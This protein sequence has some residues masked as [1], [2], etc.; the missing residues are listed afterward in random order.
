M[1]VSAMIAS[2]EIWQTT[3]VLVKRYGTEA[4]IHAA[5]RRNELSDAGDPEG[6]ATWHAVL[7]AIDELLSD[8]PTGHLN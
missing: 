5:M 4:P 8:K 2:R 7:R 6:A 1:L 3:N